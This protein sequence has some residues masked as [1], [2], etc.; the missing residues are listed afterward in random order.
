M[1]IYIGRATTEFKK[2]WAFITLN[3]LVIIELIVYPKA[4]ENANAV[5]FAWEICV[6][7]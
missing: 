2:F 6:S 5:E 1:A 7:V 4:T 3:L